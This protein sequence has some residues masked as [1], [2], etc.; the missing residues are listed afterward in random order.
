MIVLVDKNNGLLV[1][2]KCLEL[3]AEYCVI[4]GL[5]CGVYTSYNSELMDVS[6]DYFLPNCLSLDSD[7]NVFISNTDIYNRFVNDI[8]SN[9]I[10]ELADLRYNKEVSGVDVN[11][12]IIKTDRDSQATLTGAYVAVQQNPNL[13]IDWKSETGWIQI[14]KTTVEA[15]CTAVTAHVQGCFTREKQIAEIINGITNASDVVNFDIAEAW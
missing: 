5:R 12:L 8:K 9:K 6:I 2:D 7:G 14:D 11:G 13:L 4:N 3:N 1:S 10:R 15:L